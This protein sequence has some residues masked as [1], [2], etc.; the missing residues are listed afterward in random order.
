MAGTINPNVQNF[1]DSA[2]KWKEEL[3][4]LMVIGCDETLSKMT[5]IAGIREKLMLGS[6]GMN[7]Q[8]RPYKTGITAGNANLDINY[9][10]LAVEFGQLIE[11]F[12]PNSAIQTILGKMAAGKGEGMKQAEVIKMALAAVAQSASENLNACIWNAVRNANGTTTSALFNGFDTIT[13]TEK[14]AGNIAANKGNYIK[15]TTVLSSQNCCDILRGVV[16]KM[17]PVLRKQNC[18]M[19][20]SQDIYDMYVDSYQYLKGNLPYNTSFEKVYVEGSNG[21]VELCP[22]SSKAGSNFIHITPQR[23]MV[24]GYDNEGER[25]SVGV[26]KYSTNVLTLEMAMFFGVQFATLDKRELMVVEL[27]DETRTVSLSCTSGDG[28]VKIGTG[29][30]GTTATATVTKGSSVTITAT[31]ASGKTFSKWSDDD[32]NASRTITVNDNVTLTATFV[33]EE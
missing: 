31:A 18:I 27:A 13:A 25:S 12:E 11:D 4:L 21:K 20:C 9:R 14:T 17:D 8:V 19:Y 10:E 1:N 16:R 28:T 29:E 3:L 23:N 6:F 30:A 7:A 24:Y 22:L 33:A 26:E 32:T 2:K 5:G 15:L